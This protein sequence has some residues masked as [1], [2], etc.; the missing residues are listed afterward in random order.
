M[1]NVGDLLLSRRKLLKL[2]SGVT[3]GISLLEFDRPA[4]AG[5]IGGEQSLSLSPAPSPNTLTA[6]DDEFL[7]ELERATFLF[8]LEQTNPET[9][10]VRD[11]FNV[12]A[13]DKSDL[14]SIAATGFGFTALCIGHERQW[15]PLKDAR[16]RVVAGLRFLWEKMPNHRG[17]FYHWANNNTGERLWDSEVSSIDS[18]ILLC[19]VLTCRKHF[20]DRRSVNSLTTSSIVWTGRGCPKTPESCLTGGV[21]IRASCN[22]AGRTIAS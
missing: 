21:P 8:F 16:E 10:I 1:H 13:A 11:R 12:R 5:G 7:D 22:S 9:G 20:E 17:F 19:G 3:T 6:D 15:I 2:I 4:S 14:G 18:A